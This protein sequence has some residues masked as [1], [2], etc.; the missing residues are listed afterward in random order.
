M[1]KY[2]FLIGPFVPRDQNTRFWLVWCY[3]G[4]YLLLTTSVN[5]LMFLIFT[6]P[7]SIQAIGNKMVTE[8]DNVTL[9]CSASGIPPPMVS[10]MKPDGQRHSGY[11]LNV[12]NINRSQAGEYKCEVSNECGNATETSTIDVQCKFV[13]RL[14]Y[15]LSLLWPCN[16]NWHTLTLLLPKS[17]IIWP[18]SELEIKPLTILWIFV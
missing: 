8:G 14:L 18:E 12:V 6:V 3:T 9:M 11:M 13:D 5:S 17:Y 4:T 2:G 7:S 15:L 10:W 16:L 1:W